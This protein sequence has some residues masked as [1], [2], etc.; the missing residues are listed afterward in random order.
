MQ[1]KDKLVPYPI[2]QQGDNDPTWKSQHKP[3]YNIFTFFFFPGN[4]RGTKSTV[5]SVQTACKL[6]ECETNLRKAR[7]F[8]LIISL[9]VMAL[10]AVA[11]PGGTLVAL[12]GERQRERS[13]NR[14]VSGYDCLLLITYLQPHIQSQLSSNTLSK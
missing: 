9:C 10:V 6:I 5:S 3:L 11:Y 12:S 14:A 4:F 1:E 7:W 13:C 2:H 8:S